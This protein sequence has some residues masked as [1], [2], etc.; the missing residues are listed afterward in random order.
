MRALPAVF[1]FESLPDSQVIMGLF[2]SPNRFAGGLPSMS[3]KGDFF[4]AADFSRLQGHGF[5]SGM[6]LYHGNT[7]LPK[8]N[9]LHLTSSIIHLT[10]YIFHH[11]Y[12]S[13]LT[14]DIFDNLVSIP[15]RGFIGIYLLASRRVVIASLHSLCVSVDP[16]AFL[17]G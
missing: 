3:R 14:P 11:T 1:D 8:S 9:I 15:V 10:S 7:R 5:F 12:I 2:G 16:S 4:I 6:T 13:H 17:C